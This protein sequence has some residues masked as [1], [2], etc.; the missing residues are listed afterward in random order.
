M[1][2]YVTKCLEVLSRKVFITAHK[3]SNLSPSSGTAPRSFE[4]VCI[5]AKWPHSLDSPESKVEDFWSHQDKP[6][7]PNATL[8]A[9]VVQLFSLTTQ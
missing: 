1:H 2:G 9:M 5:V 8:E 6:K 4:S 7:G 3:T